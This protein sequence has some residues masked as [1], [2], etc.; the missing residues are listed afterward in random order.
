MRYVDQFLTG[1]QTNFHNDCICLTGPGVHKFSSNWLLWSA[2]F[3]RITRSNTKT[4]N[5]CSSFLPPFHVGSFS[6]FFLILLPQ[7]LLGM[8]ELHIVLI[9]QLK[10]R[11]PRFWKIILFVKQN[12][13]TS[14][15]AKCSGPNTSKMQ[16]IFCAMYTTLQEVYNTFSKTLGQI[17]KLDTNWNN[18]LQHGRPVIH[19][20]GW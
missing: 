10:T 9:M 3:A 1:P 6:Q 14:Q 16:N 19:T 17:W 13:D 8:N 4:C 12:S 2:Q 18:I 7:A 15:N 20:H 5:F 11:P